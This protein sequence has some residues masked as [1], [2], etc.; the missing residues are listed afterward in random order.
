MSEEEVKLK[1][2][3]FYEAHGVP[4]CIGA[5]NGS[6]IDIRAPRSKLSDYINCKSRYSLNVQ[7]ACDYNYCFLDGCQMARKRS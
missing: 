1:V 6:H 5:I 2:T 7:A 4:R 3:Q